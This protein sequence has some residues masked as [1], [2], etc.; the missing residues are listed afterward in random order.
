ML[1]DRFEKLRF[2]LIRLILIIFFVWP[3]IH[4]PL[5]LKLG[6]SPWKL[7]GFGMFSAPGDWI[8]GAVR[9]QVLVDCSDSAAFVNSDSLLRDWIQSRDQFLKSTQVQGM[10]DLGWDLICIEEGSEKKTQVLSDARR[11]LLVEAVDRHVEGLMIW[12]KAEALADLSDELRSKDSS[13]VGMV[14][15]VSR[16]DM[17]TGRRFISSCSRRWDVH[18]GASELSCGDLRGGSKS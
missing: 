4:L 13:L 2:F 7:G 9:L 11:L 8:D 3:A 6:V 16:I 15:L 5:S 1:F 17:N 10:E 12:P 14:R 18:K